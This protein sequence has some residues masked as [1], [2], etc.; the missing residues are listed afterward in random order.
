MDYTA[1]LNVDKLLVG[2]K[3]QMKYA[4]RRAYEPVIGDLAYNPKLIA[5]ET[6]G[7]KQYFRSQNGDSPFIYRERFKEIFSQPLL[8]RRLVDRAKTLS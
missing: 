3:R 2:P 8:L 7:V 6:M 5:F 1:T 4:L